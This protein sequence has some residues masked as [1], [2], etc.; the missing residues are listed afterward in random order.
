MVKR[1]NLDA[2]VGGWDRELLHLCCDTRLFILNGRTL[3]DKSREFT[4]LANGG[5]NIID[6]IIGS[7]AVLQVATHF[8]V[9]IDDT[10]YCV[11]GG[12]S[13][14]WP[15]CLWLNIDYSFVEPQH[16]VETIFFCLGLNMINQK[17]KSISLP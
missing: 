14:H 10:H 15:L 3:G 2:N 9:I 8:E 4:C 16:M 12:D 1:Q 7:L 11:V 17:M 13:D 5:H 6:Y